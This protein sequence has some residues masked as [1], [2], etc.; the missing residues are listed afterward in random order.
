M[1]ATEEPWPCGG[2]RVPGACCHCGLGWS[3][4]TADS[5]LSVPEGCVV[6]EL[7]GWGSMPVSGPFTQLLLKF[8]VCLPPFTPQGGHAF[9]IC[10]F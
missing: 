5:L 7:E 10:K 2:P 9:R 4:R 8:L 1:E 6:M 3:I